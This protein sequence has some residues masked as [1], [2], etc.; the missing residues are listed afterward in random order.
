MLAVTKKLHSFEKAHQK[1]KNFKVITIAALLGLDNP[2]VV[3]CRC[4]NAE[5]GSFCRSFQLA[6]RTLLCLKRMAIALDEN[7]AD[8]FHTHCC[9]SLALLI[10]TDDPRAVINR[11]MIAM[12]ELPRN[13]KRRAMPDHWEEED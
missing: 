2:P 1:C 8:N 9:N 6:L 12:V 3:V 5:K 13:R 7:S 11:N 4:P 10:K